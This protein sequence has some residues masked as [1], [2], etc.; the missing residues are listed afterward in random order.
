[1]RILHII[2]DLQ[3]GGAERNLVSL[4]GALPADQHHVVHF[5]ENAAYAPVLTALGARVEQVGANLAELPKAVRTLRAMADGAD[6]VHTQRWMSDLIGR[7]AARG[8]AAIVS[9]VQISPYE[10]W[11]LRNYSLR[12]QAFYRALWLADIALSAHVADRMVGVCDYV[13]QMI[14]KRL[15]VPEWRTR[16]VY[17]A[18]PVEEFGGLPAA[19]RDKLRA[20]LGLASDDVAIATVG[21]VVPLKGQEL[22]IE[23]MPRIRARAGKA[24]LIIIGDGSERPRLERRAAEL[25]LGDRVRWLG[26]RSDVP[27]LLGAIDIFALASHGEGLPLSVI[28]AMSSS[29]ACVLSPIPPHRELAAIASDGGPHPPRVVE[30]QD[31]A[32]WADA[33]ASLIPDDEAR[34][35]MGRQGR[36]AA[37]LHFDARVTAPAMGAVFAEAAAE[38]REKRRGGRQPA[39]G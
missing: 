22:L 34:D 12:G 20:E 5:L 16:R 37:A 8:H 19:E 21:H 18:I 7:T 27:R 10:P 31:P 17:N 33:L 11:A 15:R 30:R 14:V 2:D 36:S 3:R 35:A 24:R 25:G 4:I 29:V 38:F 13:R 1:M 9:T 23:A 28:E 39:I 26:H 32:S 6:V